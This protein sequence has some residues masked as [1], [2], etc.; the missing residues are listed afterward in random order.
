[1]S[2]GWMHDDIS[3]IFLQLAAKSG[4]ILKC[5]NNQRNSLSKLI[6]VLIYF[7]QYICIID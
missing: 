1:M 7:K 5:K 6:I 2:S 3:G 4:G